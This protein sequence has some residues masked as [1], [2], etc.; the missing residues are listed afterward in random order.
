MRRQVHAR[1]EF[2]GATDAVAQSGRAAKLP[3]LGVAFQS[4]R[5][6]FALSATDAGLVALPTAALQ[7]RYAATADADALFVS[8]SPANQI[9]SDGVVSL[10]ILGRQVD[11]S[12][13]A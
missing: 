10:S 2:L 7:K 11:T 5:Y 12:P 3:M 1:T 6:N 4:A 9:R 13:T 8:A